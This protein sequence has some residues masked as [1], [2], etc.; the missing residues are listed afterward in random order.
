MHILAARGDS[1]AMLQVLSAVL[2]GY[3]KQR[4]PLSKDETLK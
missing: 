1:E 4:G 2:H 3:A